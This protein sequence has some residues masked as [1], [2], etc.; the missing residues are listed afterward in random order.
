M[1]MR[2]LTTVSIVLVAVGIVTAAEVINVD[3]KGYGDKT[4]Y[5]GNGAYDVGNGAVWIPYSGG[6]GVPVGSSRTEGITPPVPVAQQLLSSVYAAQVWIGDN[7]QKHGY[8]WGSGLMDDG[9]TAASPNE[10]NIS[11]WGD[12]AYQGLYDLYV[13]GNDDGNFILDQNSV[14]TTKHVTGGVTPGA[15][16]NGGNYVIFTDVNV[17]STDS[18]KLYLTYTNKLNALQFVKKK[19]PFVIEPN[20]LGLIRI[21]AG[22]WDVAGDRNMRTT[23]TT[24]FGPDTMY[25][26]VNAIGRFVGYLDTLEF[27]DYDINVNDANKGQYQICLGIMGGG[28]YA[29][30]PAG[31]MRILLDDVNLGDVNHPT[32]VPAGTIGDTTT[33]TANLYP[34]IH[35]VRWLLYASGNTG[36]NLAYVK[37][38]RIGNISVGF[39]DLDLWVN[40]WLICNN[41]DPNGCL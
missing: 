8:K 17:I 12:G 29:N 22:D 15:F 9:F 5:V 36:F 13:Y 7:G 16:V 40:N 1:K 10:P 32:L 19:S 4:P 18:S 38:T 26:D 28:Q 25:D 14:K 35:T 33:V 39:Q 37:F 20:A 30:I 27:M 3:I 2:L 6:W 41:P 24:H 31:E 21:P 11:I 34:G 23:E